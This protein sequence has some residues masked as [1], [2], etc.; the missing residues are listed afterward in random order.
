MR[1]RSR[2]VNSLQIGSATDLDAFSK[3]E[4]IL[5]WPD[6]AAKF[7]RPISPG[8]CADRPFNLPACSKPLTEDP[9]ALV[10]ARRGLRDPGRETRPGPL[11]PTRGRGKRKPPL[12]LALVTFQNRERFR[13]GV[14]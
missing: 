2:T 13:K 1:W 12:R 6:R 7:C 9:Y 4:R 11:R 14:L 5:T 8:A 3:N 10:R